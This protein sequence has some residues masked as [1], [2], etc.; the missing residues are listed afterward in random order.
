MLVLN[1]L[2]EFD[3]LLVALD[4]TFDSMLGSEQATL[5]QANNLGSANSIVNKIE[6]MLPLAMQDLPDVSLGPF[7]N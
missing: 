4:L 2:K 1:P 5:N 6:S 3:L 7:P